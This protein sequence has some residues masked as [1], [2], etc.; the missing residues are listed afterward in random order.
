MPERR[1]QQRAAERNAEW[2]GY[3]DL[4]T[5][6]HVP[7]LLITFWL[8]QLSGSELKVTLYVVRHTYGYHREIASISFE[9]FLN[10]TFRRDGTRLDWGAGVKRTQIKEALPAL[11]ECGILVRER[12][13]DQQGGDTAS[14]YAV[15]LRGEES[16]PGPKPTDYKVPAPYAFTPVP[17]QLFD[18]LLPHLKEV[19][20]KAV[21]YICHHTS[22]LKE[23][24]A[25]ISR[26]QM[27]GGTVTGN[28]RILDRGVGVSE[29]SLD[30]ALK[31]LVQKGVIFREQQI[32]PDGRSLPSRYGL[33]ITA[34]HEGTPANS[35]LP[36]PAN[37]GEGTPVSS[38]RL[39][40]VNSA[41]HERHVLKTHDERHEQQHKHSKPKLSALDGVV[42]A[43]A[44]LGVTRRT[45]REL[46][47]KHPE[48]MIRTQI[49]MLPYRKAEDPAAVLVKAIREDWA[50]PAGYETPE[51]REERAR[52]EAEARAERQAA[53]EERRLHRESWP[54]RMIAKHGID[55][56]TL[57]AWEGARRLLPRFLG[58]GTCERLFSRALLLPSRNGTAKL[59]VESYPQ[60]HQVG[61][62]ERE[63][64]EI[65]LATVL[66]RRVEVEVG[67]ET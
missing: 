4:L 45:A 62:R 6:T 46:T 13:Q 21:L 3:F 19:E 20:L 37:S 66:G 1:L 34:R 9:R 5:W 54:E 63:A 59:M 31:G 22:G 23:R 56:A 15:N 50:P 42:V 57:D 41:P 27:L 29:R 44:S 12:R 8:P 58:A 10:G 32:A 14:A 51:Q 26:A 49:D 53:E 17:N 2:R 24:H 11:V 28:G 16:E 7:D 39:S 38:E 48:D 52:E 40:P 36:S 67:W 65:A 30:A 18:V 61:E 33:N 35:E 55:A 60:M 64:L 47:E 43:L 25:D